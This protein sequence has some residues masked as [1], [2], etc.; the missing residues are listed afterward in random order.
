MQ[1]PLT[2]PAMTHSKKRFPLLFA[3]LAFVSLN[4]CHTAIAHADRVIVT[5][6]G[7]NL[8]PQQI[9]G[10]YLFGLDKH[11]RRITWANIDA[12]TLEFEIVH[13]QFPGRDQ[14]GFSVQDA[15]LPETFAT[16]AVSV[17]VQDILNTT[18]HDG[19]AGY[20]RRS[21]YLAVNKSFANTVSLPYP[22]KNPSISAGLG[23][24]ITNG[25]FGS[26]RALTGF[27]LH[28]TLEFDG[29]SLNYRVDHDLFGIARLEYVRIHGRNFI[30]AE[31][32]T[33]SG[34]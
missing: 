12:N 3:L 23:T 29:R 6:S 16:P 21:L 31:I 26:V 15:I 11:T 13:V 10:E 17:G 22:F 5:P 33:P 8:A 19:A 7:T 9:Q 32:H 30:G 28:Q 25:F 4:C 1:M 14:Y 27:G 20:G 18:L 2:I 34:I 24:G